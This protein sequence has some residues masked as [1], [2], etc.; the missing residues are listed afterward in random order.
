VTQTDHFSSVAGAY[1]AYRPTYPAALFGYLAALPARRRRVWDCGAGSGQAT[2]GLLPHFESVIA[3]DISRSQ[4]AAARGRGLYRIVSFAERAPLAPH[5]ADLVIVAQ[6]LHW[7]DHAAFYAEVRRVIVPDGA[8]AVW[9]YDLMQLGDRELDGIVRD[10]YDGEVGD[11][12]PPERKLVDQRYRSIPFPFDER[13]APDFEMA[14]DWTLDEVLGY[15][16]T[17]SAVNRYRAARG[18]DPLPSLRLRL[19][20]SWGARESR[21]RVTWPLGVRAA[22]LS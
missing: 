21:R 2:L 14:A 3:T 8:I 15:V 17:W 19:E 18:R 22:R 7:F 5:S 12:W 10:F 9:S 11:F 6:A 16:G 1:A 13:P 4:L 20:S